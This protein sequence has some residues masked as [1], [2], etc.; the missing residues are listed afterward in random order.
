MQAIDRLRRVAS[1]LMRKSG[2]GKAEPDVGSFRL[3]DAERVRMKTDPPTAVHRAFF[4]SGKRP[5]HKWAH[6]LDVYDR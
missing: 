1:R 6:Y 4:E 2:L 5:A 3:S